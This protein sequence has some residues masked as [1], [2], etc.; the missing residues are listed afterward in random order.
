MYVVMD[1][2]GNLWGL[3]SLAGLASKWARDKWPSQPKHDER[4]DLP[5][6]EGWSI[7]AIRPAN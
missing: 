2:D 6:R 4:V 1:K 5:F 7:V 3:F